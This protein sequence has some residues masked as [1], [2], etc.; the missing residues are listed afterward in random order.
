MKYRILIGINRFLR[1]IETD[2][3]EVYIRCSNDLWAMIWRKR[4][5]G[6]TEAKYVLVVSCTPLS[7]LPGVNK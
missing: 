2:R 3:R 5:E 4:Q 7:Q 6:H 1:L